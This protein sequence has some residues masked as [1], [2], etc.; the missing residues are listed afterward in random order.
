MKKRAWRQKFDETRWSLVLQARGTPTIASRAALAELCRM[1][2]APLYA[3]T[4]RFMTNPEQAEDMVQDFLARVIERDILSRADPSQ[5]SFRAFLKTSLKH[6]MFNLM[7]A[8]RAQKRGGKLR[9]IDSHLLNVPNGSMSA[10]LLYDRQCAWKLV[11]RA[12][13]RLRDEQ[14]AKGQTKVFEALRDRLV[15]DEDGA[16]L[17]DEAQRL[18][19]DTVT[20]RVRLLRLRKN[21]GDLVRD[22][23]AQTVARPEEVENEFRELLASL[24]G[25]Q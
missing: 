2:R 22:E 10:E 8:E 1:Y 5:G 9:F 13:A 14:D 18:G 19:L 6:H 11:E 25:S 24:R 3:F 12:Y 21:F 17:R 20:L 4:R 23:I 7:Q 15:G 16:T